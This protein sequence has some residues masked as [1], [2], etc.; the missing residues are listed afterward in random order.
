M[1]ADL[2]ARYDTF[3]FDLD[4][5][6]WDTNSKTGEPIWAKQ[7]LLPYTI[8]GEWSDTIID[9][10]FSTCSL[11]A[12]IRPVL[13]KLQALGKNIGFLSRG[14]IYEVEYEK[15]PSVLLLKR[16]GIYEFFNYKKILLYKTDLKLYNIKEIADVCGEYVFF[17]DNEKDLTEA[18]SIGGVKAIDRN[19]FDCWE[20]IL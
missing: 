17:D 5:T 7:M 15:Q 1:I 12:G 16:F 2:A 10:V 20:S 6:V 11:H 9:D 8:E 19:S 3:I 18:A 14:G 4:R 13:E